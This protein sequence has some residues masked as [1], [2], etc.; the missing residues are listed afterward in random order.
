MISPLSQLYWA[1]FF[2]SLWIVVFPLSQSDLTYHID[3]F[4]YHYAHVLKVKRLDCCLKLLLQL[5]WF[6]V[7]LLKCLKVHNN[8]LDRIIDIRKSHF[9]IL[10]Q[11]FPILFAEYYW[12]NCSCPTFKSRG[13]DEAEVRVLYSLVFWKEFFFY[14]HRQNSWLKQRMGITQKYFDRQTCCAHSS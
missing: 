5:F 10:C 4:I 9:N 11:D 8:Y 2:G 1:T 14:Y 7:S 6:S 3:V 13:E 12:Q